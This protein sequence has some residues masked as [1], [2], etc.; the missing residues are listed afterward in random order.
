VIVADVEEAVAA[1]AR[2]A[3]A[4]EVAGVDPRTLQRWGAQDIGDDRRAGPNTV[5]SNALTSGERAVFL[6][7]ANSPRYRDKSPKQIVP[8]LADRGLYYGSESCLY[9]L[10]RD[11]DQL[12]HRQSSRPPRKVARPA[13]QEATGPNQVWSWDITYLKTP[14]R[15]LFLY[16]YMVV[17]VWSRKIVAWEVHDRESD[18]YASRLIEAACWAEGVSRDQLV[19]HSDNGSPMKGATLLATLQRLGIAASFSRPRVSDDN[20]YSEALF[21]T[22]KYRPQYPENAFASQ[23]AA[24]AWVER[25]VAWYNHEHRHSAIR[26]VTPAERHG[27]KEK[28]ILAN[29]RHVYEAA[30]RRHPERWSGKIRNCTPVE[31][32][33]LNPEPEAPL[34]QAS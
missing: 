21:R 23:D 7:V 2:Q 17:D 30:R 13:E 22:L 28:A 25:F 20:P 33:R 8:D 24:R 9:R 15:G 10:L 31:T 4:C 34:A 14:V 11:A 27:G 29:R 1:G 26:Y 12:A 6:E 32:V 5:P 16:L 19:L 3:A 18:E